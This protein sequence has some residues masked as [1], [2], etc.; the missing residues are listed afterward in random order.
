MQRE[1]A[2][3]LQRLHDP[4]VVASLMTKVSG[5]NE[6]SAGA[7]SGGNGVGRYAEQRVLDAAD[8]RNRRSD[9]TVNAAADSLNTLTGEDFG[10]EPRPWWSSSEPGALRRATDVPTRRTRGIGSGSSGLTRSLIS[11]TR[12]QPRQ[13]A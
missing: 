8:P 3:S 10:Y 2:R 13:S 12:S 6:R 9:L 1:A 7:C 4:S 11:R 5:A